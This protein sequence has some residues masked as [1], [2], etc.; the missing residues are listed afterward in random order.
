MKGKKFLATLLAMITCMSMIGC[1]SSSSQSTSASTDANTDVQNSEASDDT[2]D[3]LYISKDKGGETTD[4]FSILCGWTSDCPDDTTVQKVMREQLG[5]DY[6]CEFMQSNDYLTTLNLKLSSGAELPDIM[7]FQYN[8]SVANALVSAGRIMNLNDIY[9][10]SKLKNIPAID[11]RIQDYIRDDNGDMWYIPGYYAMEYDEPWGGWTVDSY[12][13]RTDLMKEAGVTADDITTMDGFADALRKFSQLKDDNGNNIIPLSFVQGDEKSE[14]KII[15]SSFG[16]D[17]TKGVSGMPAVEEDNGEYVFLYD[18]PKYKEA[19]KWMNEMY[20]EGLI[21]MECTTMGE[22]RFK[23]KIEKGQVAAFTTDLWISNLNE[24]WKNYESGDDSVTFYYEPFQSPTQD[25]VAKGYTSYVNPN[26]GYMVF[27][28]KDTKHLNAVLNW[29]EWCNEKDPY[30]QQEINEGPRGVNWDFVEG[31]GEGTWDFTPEYKAERDS[32]DS[33]RVN[34]CTPQLWQ[35]CTY[36]NSW[37]PWFT[38]SNGS[39]KKGAAL[40]S[41][42]CKKIGSEIVNHRPITDLDQVKVD[43]NSV[44]SENLDSMKAVVDEYTAKMIMADSDENFEKYY[45]EFLK[46]LD[47]QASWTEMKEEWVKLYNEQYGK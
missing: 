26:P 31:E 34:A 9:T 38:Q 30:R 2:G 23:E 25:G 16:V 19:Y 7:I 1:G 43:V 13:L 22:D 17:T 45:T 42:Y 3:G 6:K 41:E 44:I 8:Q 46:Q 32:G 5:I 12:W 29:L 10:S 14:E 28:N 18:N 47:L 39:N 33:S 35:F 24:T 4:Q 36:S 11:S 21:D 20:R 37:Y 27:I 40:T 15:V